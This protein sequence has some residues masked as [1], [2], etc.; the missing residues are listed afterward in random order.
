MGVCLCGRVEG[1]CRGRGEGRWDQ[2]RSLALIW[3]T[4]YMYSRLI[5]LSV[6]FNIMVAIYDAKPEGSCLITDVMLK[7]Q[8]MKKLYGV[9]QS[10]W[11]TLLSNSI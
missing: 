10:L 7:Y 4:Q 3:I 2:T 5:T 9:F 6:S 11:P 1:G 8:V